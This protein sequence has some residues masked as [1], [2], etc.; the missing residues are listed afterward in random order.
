MTIMAH[1]SGINVGIRKRQFEYKG[2]RVEIFIEQRGARWAWS[3]VVNGPKA[4]A[5]SRECLETSTLAEDA[6]KAEACRLIDREV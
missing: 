1:S 3:F 6:D 5:N 4:R 2:C